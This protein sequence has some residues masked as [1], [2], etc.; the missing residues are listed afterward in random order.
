MASF[1]STRLVLA[2]EPSKEATTP[3]EATPVKTS[4]MAD[5]F[6]VTAEVTV[7]KLFPAGFGWQASS[8]L[9]D[10]MGY[11]ATDVPFFLITG[12]GDFA[13]VIIGHS[14]YYALKKATFDSSIDM[15]DTVQTG[16]WLASAAFCSGAAWQPIV[17]FWQGIDAPFNAV[18]AGAWAGCGLMFFAGLRAG[19]SI[20]P[21]MPKSDYQNLVADAT[22]SA[23]IGGATAFFV[24]TDTA[25]MNGDGNWLRPVIGVEDADSDIVGCIKAGT[26]T[27]LGFFAAQAAQNAVYPAGKC[28]LD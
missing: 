28:W 10:G 13:G 23:S 25:Y 1:H 15:K 14:G 9:A 22:L 18:F 4:S 12:G 11:G 21:F 8:I 7:S 16:L 6:V 2:D 3:P 5:R 17:N 19:R 26:S 20:Y 24:G 27:G